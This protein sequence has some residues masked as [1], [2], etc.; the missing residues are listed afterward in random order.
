MNKIA[1]WV[2]VITTILGFVIFWAYIVPVYQEN[3]DAV[4]AEVSSELEGDAQT[5]YETTQNSF[6]NLVRNSI[7][8]VI[9]VMLL[10]G[11]L[12]MQ[13]KER[14]EGYYG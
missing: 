2:T 10:W 1:V 11:Y 7:G 6:G 14:V 5:A 8:G 9:V 3:T 13:R 12:S 4:D